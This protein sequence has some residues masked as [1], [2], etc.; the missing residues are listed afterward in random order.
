MAFEAP[1]PDRVLS[2]NSRAHWRQVS[3]AKARYRRDLHILTIHALNRGLIVLPDTPLIGVRLTWHPRSAKLPDDDNAVA[4]FKAG[5]DGIADALRIDDRR[6]RYLPLRF[7]DPV[8]NGKLV[9]EIEPL[10]SDP[11]WRE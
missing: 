6:M 8:A 7:G 4:S 5:R 9:I 11:G 2:P 10:T 1:L 3:A